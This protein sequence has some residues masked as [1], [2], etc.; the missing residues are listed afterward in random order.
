MRV[1]TQDL[2]SLHAPTVTLCTWPVNALAQKINVRQHK[3][4]H[5]RLNGFENLKI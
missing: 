4:C 5:A 2:A 1:G 3:T